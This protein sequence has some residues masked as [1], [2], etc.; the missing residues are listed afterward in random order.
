MKIPQQR[1]R[2]SYIVRFFIFLTNFVYQALGAGLVGRIFTSYESSDRLFRTSL[3][4]RLAHAAETGGGKLHRT[5]RRQVALAMNESLLN[6]GLSGLLRRLCRYSLRTFG[7]FLVTAGIYSAVM[8]WLVAV[9]W[10]SNTVDIFHLFSGAAML[11]L[12]IILLEHKNLLR[13]DQ[14]ER[15]FPVGLLQNIIQ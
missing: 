13:T 8:Y 6:R 2:D 14:M 15:Q 3:A 9:V 10:Q 1:W 12:G 7:T 4:G 11:V 5:V